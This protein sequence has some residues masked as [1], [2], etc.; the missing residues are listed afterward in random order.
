M[1]PLMQNKKEKENVLH[2][3]KLT[4][5]N[6]FKHQNVLNRCSKAPEVCVCLGK[7]GHVA[8]RHESTQQTRKA[9]G[10]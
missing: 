10:A 6:D 4:L 8:P 1:K 5:K 2:R 3:Q 7:L 9:T